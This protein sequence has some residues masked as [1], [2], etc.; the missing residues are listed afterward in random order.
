[1]NIS[2]CIIIVIISLFL[3]IL[4]LINNVKQHFGVENNRRAAFEKKLVENKI[5]SKIDSQYSPQECTFDPKKVRNGFY[6]KVE[7]KN[8]CQS[9]DNNEAFGGVMCNENICKT[10]CE[11][12]YDPQKC[13][14]AQEDGGNIKDN[15]PNPIEL[16]RERN[17]KLIWTKPES[18]FPITGYLCVITNLDNDDHF[19]VEIPSDLKC[20]QCEHDLEDLKPNTNYSI[21]LFSRNMYGYSEPSNSL[22]IKTPSVYKTMIEEQI[23]KRE[24]QN[25]LDKLLEIERSEQMYN[26]NLKN[27]RESR[28]NT[29]IDI[30]T[31]DRI[32]DVK[33]HEKYNL[34]LFFN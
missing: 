31:E 8:Y 15:V 19:E 21:Q 26:L 18:E 30:L 27:I 24:E 12:C 22:D 4:L 20:E 23:Q 3:L 1:M 13:R 11:Q 14:W 32:N 5:Y 34:D 33:G 28:V 9:M 6:N 17:N 25:K 29:L 16:E 7:C 10:K 2:L